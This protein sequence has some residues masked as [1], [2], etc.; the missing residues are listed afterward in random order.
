MPFRPRLLDLSALRD[1]DAATESER[2]R[3]TFR[4]AMLQLR[5]QANRRLRR[6]GQRGNPLQCRTL[7]RGLDTSQQG[8]QDTTAYSCRRR[9][10][11]MQSL[12]VG[13]YGCCGQAP[14]FLVK[15]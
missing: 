7:Y 4:M 12:P 2:E 1:S 9:R 10:H 3:A 11:E 13:K 15:T 5:L 14:W 6:D 8:G